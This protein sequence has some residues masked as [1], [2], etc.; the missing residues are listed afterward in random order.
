MCL[1]DS[2]FLN[3]LINFIDFDI[4]FGDRFLQ[5]CQNEEHACNT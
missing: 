2:D 4:W 5:V 3:N 1:S